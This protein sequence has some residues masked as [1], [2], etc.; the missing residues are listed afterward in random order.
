MAAKIQD[1]VQTPSDDTEV[2]SW[3]SYSG[4]DADDGTCAPVDDGV[5]EFQL[6]HAEDDLRAWEWSHV[7]CKSFRTIMPFEAV[8]ARVSLMGY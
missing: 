5:D 1:Y 2:T 3:W 4:P 7:S 8:K 6:W